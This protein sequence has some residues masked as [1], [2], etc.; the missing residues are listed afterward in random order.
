MRKL[1]ILSRFMITPKGSAI[2]NSI[3]LKVSYDLP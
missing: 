2:T 3:E 1:F